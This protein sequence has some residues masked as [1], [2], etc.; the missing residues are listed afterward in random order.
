ML[1]YCLNVLLEGIYKQLPS[2]TITGIMPSNKKKIL[3][4]GVKEDRTRFVTLGVKLKELA[5]CFECSWG[6]VGLQ[7]TQLGVTEN[8]FDL[9]VFMLRYKN[10]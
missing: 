8:Q 3:H 1:K 5:N 2:R 9:V 7:F 10:Q 6:E 4:I